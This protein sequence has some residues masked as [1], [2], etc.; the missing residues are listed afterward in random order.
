[1]L[2]IYMNRPWDTCNTDTMIDQLYYYGGSV[3]FA[4]GIMASFSAVLFLILSVVDYGIPMLK[5]SSD[6]CFLKAIFFAVI[7]WA[8]YNLMPFC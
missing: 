7:C 2:N 6:I 5:E 3:L 1:M 4:V 8:V